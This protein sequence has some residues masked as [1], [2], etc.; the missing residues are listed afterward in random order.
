MVEKL[1]AAAYVK[2]LFDGE[3]SVS[4]SADGRRLRVIR[5]YNT[6]KSII[7]HAVSCLQILTITS[8]VFWRQ[9]KRYPHWKPICAVL[10][11]GRRNIVLFCRYINATSPIKREKLRQLRCSYR[12]VGRYRRYRYHR[13][14]SPLF[15]HQVVKLYSE[16]MTMRQVGK[17][18]AC[19][20]ETISQVL[21]LKDYPIRH[22]S[23]QELGRMGQLAKQHRA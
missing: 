12:Q 8:T 3:G 1:L 11:Q 5:I 22:Y 20:R 14:K 2:G 10:I 13:L 18:L 16:G 19:T 6:D 15:C 7:D 9:D 23:P 21:K 4:Q 17:K